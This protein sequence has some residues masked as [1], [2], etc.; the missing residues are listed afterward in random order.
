MEK[1]RLEQQQAV[2]RERAKKQYY[3]SQRKMINE[4]KQVKQKTD[5]L[6]KMKPGKELFFYERHQNFNIPI[7]TTTDGGIS[8]SQIAKPTGIEQLT[9]LGAD[10]KSGHVQLEEHNFNTEQFRRRDGD[11]EEQN[12]TSNPR[13]SAL[14]EEDEAAANQAGPDRAMDSLDIL[15]NKNG[16]TLS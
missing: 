7:T 16:N 2:Q 3:E 6:L 14:D 4:Y 9:R 1:A 15:A 8:A 12:Y 11:D 5:D 10:I 13:G